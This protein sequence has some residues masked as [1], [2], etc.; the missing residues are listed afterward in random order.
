MDMSNAY[1]AWV[2]KNLRNA[3]VVYDHFHVIKAVNDRLD[4]VR[5]RVARDMDAATREAVKGNRRLFLRNAD[6]LVEDV[7]TRIWI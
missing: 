1:S 3:D 2:F 6:E 5:R 7:F 4:K